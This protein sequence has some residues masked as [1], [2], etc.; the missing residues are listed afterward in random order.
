LSKLNHYK[1]S[2]RCASIVLVFAIVMGISVAPAASFAQDASAPPAATAPAKP[3]DTQ[4]GSSSDT[5]S[6]Q[7]AEANETD[8]YRKSKTVQWFADLLH[9]KVDQ[10]AILFDWINFAIIALAVGIPLFKL[11]P[12]AL[13]QRKA[14][15][16]F[17][18][19]VAKSRTADANTRL[20]AVEARM[21]GLDAEIAKIRKQVEEDMRQDEARSKTQLEDESARIVAAAEQE[22]VMAGA[23]AQRSLKQFAADL[24]IDRALS[25]LTLDAETDS[26]LIAEFA[27]DIAGKHKAR[28]T[29][30]GQN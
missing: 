16:S 22:I 25:R 2:F 10:A 18:L 12:K 28:S 30:G 11:L 27:Q 8:A 20:N 17:E 19:D 14:K 23:M 21:A 24:A 15:L 13:K 29:K 9:M 5:K 7:K 3:V 4:A 26:A 1:S 6:E